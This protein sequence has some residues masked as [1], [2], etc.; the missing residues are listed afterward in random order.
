[1]NNT[2]LAAIILIVILI[3]VL[4]VSA[5]AEDHVSSFLDVAK[6]KVLSLFFHEEVDN[7]VP[8]N[9]LNNSSIS[10]SWSN[11]DNVAEY[12]HV[13]THKHLSNIESTIDSLTPGTTG[14]SLSYNYNISTVEITSN[15]KIADGTY[16]SIVDGE[17][18]NFS[19]E[20]DR[21]TREW[22]ITIGSY[23]IVRNLDIDS[24]DDNILTIG[25]Q[26]IMSEDNGGNV[27][28]VTISTPIIRN[29]NIALQKKDAALPNLIP[30]AG[31]IYSKP[32]NVPVLMKN[33]LVKDSNFKLWMVRNPE[34]FVLPNNEWV[35]YYA[36]QLYITEDG[37]IKYKNRP[38][39]YAVNYDGTIL[40]WIDEPFWNKYISDDI[41]FDYPANGDMWQNADYYLFHGFKGD[42]EDWAI[43]TASLMLSGEMSINEN[44]T[45]VR[46]V[47]PAKVV[48]GHMKTTGHAWTEYI[49]H[50]ASFI[51]SVGHWINP[52]DGS[53]ESTL[54]FYPDTDEEWKN[55]HP[56]YQFSN[57]YFHSYTNRFE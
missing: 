46:Q 6:G 55:F 27:T 26:N 1:M 5:T 15:G 9:P 24:V 47:I 32:T 16:R 7:I 40:S 18:G 39:P 33:E 36:S 48:V 44:G 52:N 13:D 50:N 56:I 49:V 38:I 25:N 12:A 22:T 45:Y 20:Y 3:T 17:S 30:D 28:N 10:K 51:T 54:A 21:V 4:S 35:K 57:A 19:L 42:C 41:Q 23:K 37:I 29:N 43:A 53:S 2:K 34:S 8:V 14:K 31:I 11:V